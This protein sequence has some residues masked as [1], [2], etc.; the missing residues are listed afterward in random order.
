MAMV[1]YNRPVTINPEWGVKNLINAMRQEGDRLKLSPEEQKMV[2]RIS[3]AKL[4][5]EQ[6]NALRK[7][8]S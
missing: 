2:D 4:T 3:S 7:K 6:R 8:L 5:P 1:S